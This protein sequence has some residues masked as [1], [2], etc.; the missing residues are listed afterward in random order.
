[1]T[2]VATGAAA[3]ETPAAVV[4]TGVAAEMAA[5]VAIGVVVVAAAIGVAAVVAT[6]V[7]VAEMAAAGKPT[8]PFCQS[9][10][11]TLRE[12]VAVVPLRN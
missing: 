7:V 12:L 6:G 8:G 2:V 3:V 11:F 10:G 9:F 4:V 5:A 1:V